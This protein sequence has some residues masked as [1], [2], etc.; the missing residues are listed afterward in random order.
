MNLS[1]WRLTLIF[2]CATFCMLTSCQKEKVAVESKKS[3]EA[4][5]FDLS[6]VSNI[7]VINVATNMKNEGRDKNFYQYFL[8][9]NGVPLW[10]KARKISKLNKYCMMVP[11]VKEGST[12]VEAFIVAKGASGDNRIG[13]SLYK[14]SM[15]KYYGFSP[16]TTFSATNV[17]LVLNRFNKDI[18]KKET[19]HISY[20]MEL[21]LE[22]R[23]KH[24]DKINPKNLIGHF[25]SD[26]SNT[27]KV[28]LNS[29][30]CVP[31]YEP[32]DMWY[33]PDGDD[34]PEHDSGNE[35]YAY[36]IS[37]Y[38]MDICFD[39][40]GGGYSSA[41]NWWVANPQLSGGGGGGS[42]TIEQKLNIMLKPGDSYEFIDPNGPQ[43]VLL[44]SYGVYPSV[45]DFEN[46]IS[47]YKLEIPA[48]IV[49][50]NGDTILP[51]LRVNKIFVGGY[52]FYVKLKKDSTN[53]FTFDS[54]ASTEWGLTFSWSWTTVTTSNSVSGDIITVDIIGT[55]NYNVFLEGIGTVYKSAQ[56]YRITINKN[57][58]KVLSFQKI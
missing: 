42:L 19:F 26:V 20:A 38:V 22:I 56:H 4:Q 40:G 48:G 15:M 33:D 2:I 1:T 47:T 35:Y 27:L 24:P 52:D 30:T 49:I 16:S 28:Q 55:E 58:G 31:L 36:T 51:K 6:S 53:V 5:L 54:V 21:P 17:E 43:S 50:G 32:I 3:I 13:F 7:D 37:S 34:D 9:E 44:E 11:L 25:K 10:S 41:N 8:E 57:T 12:E 45:E 14:K 46:A 23:Q 39:S 18:F 29:L